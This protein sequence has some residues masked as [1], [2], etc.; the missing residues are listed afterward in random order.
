[1]FTV[2]QPDKVAGLVLRTLRDDGVVV[3]LNGVEIYRHYERLK[4]EKRL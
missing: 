4:A 3:Y 1:M 2:E